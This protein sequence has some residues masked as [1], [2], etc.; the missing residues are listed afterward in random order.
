MT[1][2]LS[3]S[4][5]CKYGSRA[6]INLYANLPRLPLSSS[7]SSWLS[8]W[9]SSHACT[10]FD[11][12]LNDAPVVF[13]SWC[14]IAVGMPLKTLKM[15]SRDEGE[16]HNMPR[17][18]KARNTEYPIRNRTKSTDSTP[19]VPRPAGMAGWLDQN[20]AGKRKAKQISRVSRVLP[21]SIHSRSKTSTMS[22]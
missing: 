6:L 17:M 9:P 13:L 4:S 22:R 2:S 21:L 5:S 1:L 8:P 7:S 12:S 16:Q 18:K 10:S 20:I 14:A 11:Q 3:L 15:M 19:S